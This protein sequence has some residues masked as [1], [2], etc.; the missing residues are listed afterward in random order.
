MYWYSFRPVY[1]QTWRGREQKLAS[2]YLLKTKMPVGS[3]EVI[4]TYPHDSDAYTQG[5]LIYDGF[6]YE[7]TGL[8]GK[9][10]IFKKD[11]KTGKTLQEAWID[12]KYFGEGIV[13]FKNKIYQLTWQSETLIIHDLK[14]FKE[15]KKIGLHGRRMGIDDKWPAFVHE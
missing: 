3:I 13:I 9:S 7:S 10:A 12:K 4:R 2:D 1:G 6:L 8:Y 11:L 14:T 5:L 15:I